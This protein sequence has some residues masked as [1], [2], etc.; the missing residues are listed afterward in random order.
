[1]SSTSGMFN[2]KNSGMV[3]GDF[4]TSANRVEDLKVTDK[5]H[6]LDITLRT[7]IEAMHVSQYDSSVQRC[8]AY[9]EDLDSMCEEVNRGLPVIIGVW[10]P[11]G[12]HAIVG[13]GVEK[14]SDTQSYLYV[15]DC[16]FPN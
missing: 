13:Y 15:Y 5:N 7:W 9:N 2:V 4:N 8:F 12:G 1:M 11:E 6:K 14:I 16:N 3:I 10:G